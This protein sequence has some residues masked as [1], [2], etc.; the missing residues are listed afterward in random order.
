MVTEIPNIERDKLLA[1]VEHLKRTMPIMLEYAALNA[2]LKRA[3]PRLCG[4]G[5]HAEPGA[6]ALQVSHYLQL[7]ESGF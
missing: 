3:V 4:A 5:V 7:R 1:Q 2:Q 6:R